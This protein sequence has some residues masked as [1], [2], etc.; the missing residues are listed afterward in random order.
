MSKV[1]RIRGGVKVGNT[2]Q[3][4]GEGAARVPDSSV[5]SDIIGAE[6]HINA[7]IEKARLSARQY[8]VAAQDQ[9]PSMVSKIEENAREEARREEQ[10][11]AQ[12]SRSAIASIQEKG[13]QEAKA[14]RARLDENFDSAVTYIVGQVT[15]IDL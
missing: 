15:H 5:L 10:K 1:S 11:I 7:E 6:A 14:L 8:V 4:G 9:I 3:L 2:S 13:Q 12:A